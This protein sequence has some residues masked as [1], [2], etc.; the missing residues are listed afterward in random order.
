MQSASPI[1]SNEVTSPD[2]V[3]LNRYKPRTT[4]EKGGSPVHRLHLC[5]AQAPPEGQDFSCKLQRNCRETAGSSF[6]K[7]KFQNKFNS[8]E[9]TLGR[10][11]LI[12]NSHAWGSDKKQT[13]SCLLWGLPV[14][15]VIGSHRTPG[16]SLST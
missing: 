14:C 4:A 1:K 5:S 12:A 3:G 9:V 16:R 10:N 15:G 13:A 7:K 2:Q 6:F 8:F 11:Q